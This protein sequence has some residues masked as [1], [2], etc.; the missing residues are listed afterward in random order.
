MFVLNYVN[1]NVNG[2]K[3]LELDTLLFFMLIC[4]SWVVLDMFLKPKEFGG[5]L[6][7]FHS[8]IVYIIF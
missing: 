3:P 5:I 7:L 8:F 2:L 4:F 6:F 1:R